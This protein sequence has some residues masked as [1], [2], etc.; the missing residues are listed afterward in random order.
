V[1]GRVKLGLGVI[2]ASLIS[3]NWWE[4]PYIAF[5][6]CRGIKQ[7]CK[8]G[9]HNSCVEYWCGQNNALALEGKGKYELP[10]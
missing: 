9:N 2:F 7:K 4:Y 5:Q 6:K 1:K 8:R 10:I 3:E